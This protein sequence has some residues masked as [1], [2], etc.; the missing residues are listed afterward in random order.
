MQ[1]HHRDIDSQFRGY[2]C[3]PFV[4]LTLLINPAVVMWVPQLWAYQWK[5]ISLQVYVGRYIL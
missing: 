3:Y 2:P 5:Y 4:I 1:G